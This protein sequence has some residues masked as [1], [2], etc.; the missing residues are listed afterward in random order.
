MSQIPSVT[1]RY[2]N[3]WL[4]GASWIWD[5]QRSKS[6]WGG[7]KILNSMC[8]YVYEILPWLMP[9]LNYM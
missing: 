4:D 8:R 6:Q 5:F 3:L 2:F 1:L 9:C 7:K